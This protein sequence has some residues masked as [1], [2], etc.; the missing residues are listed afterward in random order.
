[1][2]LVPYKRGPRECPC[3][4]HYVKLQLEDAVYELESGLSLDTESGGALILD[5]QAFR[6]IR[7]KILLFVHY[8]NELK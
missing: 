7:N 1:M 2:G 5:F 3:P 4:F 8:P 6:T